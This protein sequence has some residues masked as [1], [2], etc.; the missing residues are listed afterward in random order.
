MRRISTDDFGIRQ[1]FNEA[2]HENVMHAVFRLMLTSR[3]RGLAHFERRN[4][5]EHA[6]HIFCP[7]TTALLLRTTEQER[8]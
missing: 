1:D 6:G 3:Q 5:R 7:C 8:M 2:L 4:H